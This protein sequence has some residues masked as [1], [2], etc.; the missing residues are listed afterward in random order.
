MIESILIQ[1][2]PGTGKS[3][4][5]RNIPAKGTLVLKPNN[6][7]FPWKGGDSTFKEQGGV[8]MMSKDLKGIY[9]AVYK[10]L[11]GDNPSKTV[12][13]Q[14]IIEDFSHFLGATLMSD[15][16]RARESGNEAFKRYSDLA[17]DIYHS[18]FDSVMDAETFLKTSEKKNEDAKVIVINH[19]EEDMR[20]KRK[21]KTAGKLLE[22]EIMP[23]SHFRIA[24]HSLS[25]EGPTPEQ[26]YKFLTQDTAQYEAK[27]PMGMF[28]TEYIPNDLWAALETIRAYDK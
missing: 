9:N 16:F 18:L 14:I 17:A 21:F 19:T 3:T 24:L 20:G 13:Q 1:G 22:K 8:I 10:G 26:R 7:P 25:I 11:S 5:L 23:V 12:F 6:K 4:S 2:E 27:S 15:R 28:E